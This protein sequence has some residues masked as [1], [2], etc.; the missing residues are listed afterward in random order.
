MREIAMLAGSLRGENP[1]VT[2]HDGS[3]MKENP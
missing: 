1:P 3:V 2:L